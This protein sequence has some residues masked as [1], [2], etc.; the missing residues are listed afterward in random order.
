MMIEDLTTAAAWGAG[1]FLACI[2]ALSIM[3]GAYTATTATIE[4]EQAGNALGVS[5]MW[6]PWHGCELS[7][8]GLTVRVG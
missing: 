3:V 1:L 8:Y 5:A 4:C 2:A 6:T 7:G